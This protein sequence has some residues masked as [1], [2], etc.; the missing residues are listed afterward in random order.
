MD[1]KIQH[2]DILKYIWICVT[3]I[4]GQGI[5]VDLVYASEE[6]RVM[7]VVGYWQG[8]DIVVDK[9]YTS[10]EMSGYYGYHYERSD[11]Y[12][13]ELLD[14]E[15]G[16]LSSTSFSKPLVCRV[17]TIDFH[18]EPLPR[19]HFSVSLPFDERARKLVIKKDAK[20]IW[21]RSRSI[22]SPLLAVEYPVNGDVVKDAVTIK[23][24][25]YDK[26]GDNLRYILE[27]CDGRG[28]F[29]VSRDISEVKDRIINMEKL[30]KYRR[31]YDQEEAVFRI[32]CSDGFN[33]TE[34]IA[35][36]VICNSLR[37]RWASPINNIDFPLRQPIEV[38]FNKT[39]IEE[40]S[41][42]E[43]SF[44]LLEDGLY[45]I[46]GDIELDC[47]DYN[48]YYDNCR[49]LFKPRNLLKP[50][51]RYIARVAAGIKDVVGNILNDSY[52]WSFSTGRWHP[53]I[54]ISIEGGKKDVS[55]KPVIQVNF[56]EDVDKNTINSK[57]F[58]LKDEGGKPIE[59]AVTYDV[60]TKTAVL[61]PLENLAFNT[62]YK[63]VFT[64]A[65]T[66]IDGFPLGRSFYD[67]F[68]TGKG[69]RILDDISDTAQ[70]LNKDGLYE[71]LVL[72]MQVQILKP[73]RYNINADLRDPAGTNKRVA[74]AIK[75]SLDF[76]QPGVY[77][78]ELEFKGSDIARSAVDGPYEVHGLSIF[79]AG[80]GANSPPYPELTYNF[81]NGHRTYPYK[82][83]E[84]SF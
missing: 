2:S 1:R 19:L 26:D 75:T 29:V 77:P 57:A 66:S 79:D 36:I 48:D 43:E 74:Y 62:K 76:L 7:C 4:I 63:V 22:N 39:K 6:K 18:P 61:K 9:V 38:G 34:S 84:F 70:D 80:D 32:L 40:N 41:I 28:E 16:L 12:V 55:I 3:L 54:Y 20:I 64:T 35:K 11:T 42:N 45:P 47:L 5:I 17:F 73:G 53:G 10:T 14:K 33:T 56:K 83:K 72:K 24:N 30:N 65:I 49:L 27:Y 13:V 52:E 71:K 60:A 15:E 51:T 44:L 78:V 21:T 23:V 50:G 81:P 31:D 82:A 68:T 8:G 67:V 59:L 58:I 37:I 69:V 25:G 46:E